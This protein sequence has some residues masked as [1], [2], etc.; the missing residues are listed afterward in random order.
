MSA[1]PAGHPSGIVTFLFTDV[2]GST[3]LWAADTEATAHSFV[4]HDKLIRET[5]S[6][7]DGYVFGFAGDSFRG[8]FADA[9]SAVIAA[10]LVQEALRNIDWGP[11]PPLRV[12]MG[13]H[14]GRATYRDGDYFGPVP[15]TASRIEAAANGGQ[16]LMS[17]A[18][19][20][21]VNFSTRYLGNHR[22]RDVDEPVSIYQLGHDSHRTLRTI[23]PELST[24]PNSGSQIV[25]REGEIH[26]IRGLLE[27]SSLVTLTGAGGCGK[28]RLALE[29]AHRELPNRRDGCYFADLSA[30]S[31]ESELPAALASSI[32]LQL[33][34]G[35]TMRQVV[36]HLAQRE[37]LILLDN[38]EHLLEVCA[39]FA[40]DL[41][42]RSGST[43]LLTTSRQR[44]DVAGEAV[45]IVSSLS[46]TAAEPAAV[47]LFV[48]RAKT[49]Y[50]PFTDDEATRAVIAEICD[51]LDAM[52][53]PIELAAARI[54]VMSPS[55]VLERMGDRFR[56]LSGGRGRQRRRTLQ[57]TLDWSFDL[58]DEDEQQF[59]ASIGVF[60]GSFDLAAAVA[61]SG[62]DE[63]E[64]IDLIGSLVAKSLITPV[65]TG[66]EHSMF[67]LLETV[68]IYAGDQLSRRDGITAAREAHLSHYATL[69]AAESWIEA[70]DLDRSRLLA[71]HWPNIVSALEWA[72][73]ANNWST[74]AQIATGCQ[75][76]WES[77]VPAVE[78]HRWLTL[79]AA[80][81]DPESQALAGI[82]RNQA[83]LAM[84]VDEFEEVHRL[85]TEII[86]M[87]D[88]QAKLLA[89]SMH[90]FTRARQFPD[91]A[92]KLAEQAMAL[93]EKHGFGDAERAGVYWVRGTL[94]LYD[95]DVVGALPLFEEGMRNI[96]RVDHRFNYSVVLALS[97]ATAQLI[98]G[99]PED[100]LVT[101]DSMDFSPS[102]WDSSELIRAIALIDHGQV[103]LAADL[104]VHYGRGALRG[105]LNRQANDALVG[106]AALA[107]NRGETDHGWALLQ[108][109]VTPRMPFT[110]ALAEALA[111]RVGFGDDLRRRHRERVTPL[112][113]LDATDYLRV[114]LDRLA[115]D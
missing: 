13:L 6:A 61:V 60:V 33:S 18:V 26:R 63:Y 20:N 57:A 94:H 98:A 105:R 102:I 110:I 101:L 55:E 11:G 59:F 56:L 30:V 78:G 106:L 114:E 41:L 48:E 50:P 91:E 81:L 64:A 52:P 87:N 72:T 38:C 112:L 3:R 108:Q 16:I 19:N 75:G 77:R 28:T 97:T 15:N 32:R 9:N 93:I 88:P 70:E 107:L 73:S 111:A 7:N 115:A 14:R 34:S 35:D 67:R 95:H 99:R 47:D 39:R 83:M 25:G 21:E 40:E 79:I 1:E 113:E 92:E 2:E 44:L 71:P 80:N 23:D 74:A 53:L 96:N 109:A 54:S 76:L 66:E 104:V 42:A 37:A 69:T 49:V 5:I 46:N 65:A 82:K 43:M 12:R 4:L 8:A 84:Q 22:L 17:E 100:A 85:N 51:R 31:D 29:V 24:L 58:L 62:V 36:D 86:E 89:L 90:A 45:V 10:K 68:R 27:T 103:S